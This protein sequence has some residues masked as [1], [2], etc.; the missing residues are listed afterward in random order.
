[1]R[2]YL[3][4]IVN[5]VIDRPMCSTHPAYPNIVYPVN[6]GY[7]PGVIG[8]DGEYQDVYLLGVDE[9][10]EE[11]TAKIIGIVH[12][13]NDVENKLVAAPEGMI[14]NQA[15]MAEMLDFQERFFDSHFE[16]IFPKSCGALVYRRGLEGIE[17]L[18]LKQASG[19]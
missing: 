2:R 4:K 15:Q 14:F 8:G 7:I 3:G 1:M 17:Y 12:R 16:S 10:V 19:I 6:Y 9:P 11:Y 5:I 13:E 18:C